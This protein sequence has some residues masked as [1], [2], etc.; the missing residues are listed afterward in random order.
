M[1][2]Y[3]NHSLCKKCPY[4]DYNQCIYKKRFYQQFPSKTDSKLK[5]IHKC[6]LYPNIF[7]KNQIVLVDLHHQLIK[8]DGSWIWAIAKKD[9]PGVIAGRRGSK[10]IV[11]LFEP[12][13]LFRRKGRKKKKEKVRLI[14]YCS[15]NAKDIRPL[16]LNR[17]CIA[18]VQPIPV[19]DHETTAFCN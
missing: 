15:K 7:R 1:K 10:F 14:L 3:F 17:A 19:P 4:Y 2:I 12:A 8:P 6:Q 11:E 13:F 18:Q 9:V 5:A 16:L